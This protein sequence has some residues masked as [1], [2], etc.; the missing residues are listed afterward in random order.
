MMIL[1]EG[2]GPPQAG[3]LCHQDPCL[4]PNPPATRIR[5]AGEGGRGHFVG[6]FK[7]I[8]E[9]KMA[10]KSTGEELGNWLF[11]WRSYLPLTTIGIFLI[12]LRYF[13]YPYD[14]HMLDQLWEILCL[15]VSSSGLALR[16]ITAGS[17][18]RGTSG[19]N[20]KGQVAEQLNTTGM[21][22]VVR[23]PFYL[24]NFIIW[25]GL[26]LF[27]RLWWVSISL[28]LIFTI[29]YGFIIVA[30]ERFLETKFGQAYRDWAGKTP[31]FLPRF[32]GWQPSELPFSFKVAIKREYSSF[33]AMIT[34][35][36]VLEIFSTFVVEKDYAIDTIWVVIF[37]MSLITYLTIRYIKKNTNLLEV[38]GR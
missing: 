29:I 33:F 24:G 10:K 19:R 23:H 7:G 17:I 30:E 27:L 25:V 31:A 38:A 4:P 37:T 9:L 6:P 15:F 32:K 14:E 1:G 26:S 16:F 34:A 21:Y 3:H 18:P 28:I 36:F 11:R 2:Q 13:R 8:V 5:V 20:T 22:S 35:F 12:G